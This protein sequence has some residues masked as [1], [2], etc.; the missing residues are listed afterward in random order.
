VLAKGYNLILYDKNSNFLGMGKSELSMLGF[1]DM[2]EFKSNFNDFADLFV[3]RPGYISKFKNFSWID[4]TIH[5]GAPNKNILMKHKNGTEIEGKVTIHE[6]ELINENSSMYCIEIATTLASADYNIKTDID[7][8]NLEEKINE[9]K[10]IEKVEQNEVIQTFEDILTE[11][12]DKIDDDDNEEVGESIHL[13][14][15]DDENKDI[16]DD[17]KLHVEDDYDI[18]PELSIKTE[19][20]DITDDDK[21][22]KLKVS[23]DE[24]EDFDDIATTPAEIKNQET[25]ITFNTKQEP[26]EDNF[27][28]EEVEYENIDFMRIAE[29]TGLNLEDIA[30]IIEDFVQESKEYI[31]KSN[32]D[33][34]D[35]DFIKNEAMKL[36]GIASNLKITKI[37][38]T[39]NLI[40]ESSDNNKEKSLLQLFQKQIKNLE[41]QLL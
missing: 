29:D 9:N 36:K 30:E 11:D 12:Q 2:E 24:N 10:K 21:P 1:E 16:E 25:D 6:I 13:K 37:T 32:K 26:I 14:I 22:I 4:Y 20:T 5:S 34:L 3:N 7:F 40:L 27:P 38:N 35:M 33:I 19:P 41:E 17:F 15:T 8:S 31:K 23:F 28:E 18:N 39:L